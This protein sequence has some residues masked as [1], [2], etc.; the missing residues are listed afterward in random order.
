MLAEACARML[1]ESRAWIIVEERAHKIR[2]TEVRASM[3]KEARAW[4]FLLKSHVCMESR[5]RTFILKV[6]VCTEARAWTFPKE[7]WSYVES[8]VRIMGKG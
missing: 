4:M 1:T 5:A 6:R 3:I 7:R 2:H 8:R